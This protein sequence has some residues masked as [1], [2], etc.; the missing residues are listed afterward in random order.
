M[1]TLP[2]IP[3]RTI[4]WDGEH[5]TVIDQRHLPH[6]LVLHRWRSVDDVAAGIRDMQVRGA[7]L[8]GVAA[9]HGVA[10]AM[11]TKATDGALDAAL[12]RLAA[13]RPTAVNLRAA[14]ERVEAEVR[15]RPPELRFATARVL[16]ERVAD[17]DVAA[18]RAIGEAGARLLTEIHVRT[19]RPVQVLTH[20]NA[21][22][23]ACVEWGTATAPVYVAREQGVPVHVWVSE[24]RPRNQGSS[25]TAWELDQRGVPH[26]VVVDNAA[27]HLLRSGLVDCVIVGADRVAANGDVANKVGTYLKALAARDNDVPFWVAVPFTSIDMRAPSGSVI[28]IEER[29]ASEVLSV[30]GRTEGGSVASVSVTPSGTSARNWGFDVT[31][32]RLVS[33]LLTDRGVVPAAPYALAQLD[34]DPCVR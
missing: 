3:K 15:P 24:T 11:A 28:P 9:A 32:A 4:W 8:I 10:L 1:S 21:G 25:L 29:S 31:P 5:V 19:G 6:R 17:E 2:A 7:P 22:F 12:T 26:T 30:R 14:L 33:A 13:T 27:G 20:C 18:C 23:L 34:A 16:A